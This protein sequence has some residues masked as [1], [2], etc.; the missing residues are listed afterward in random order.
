MAI[1]DVGVPEATSCP[2][3]VDEAL[4][5]RAT[6]AWELLPRMHEAGHSFG[7]VSAA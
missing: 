2:L 3:A 7:L 1:R 6:M 4:A 5:R